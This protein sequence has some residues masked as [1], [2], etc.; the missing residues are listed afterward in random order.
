MKIIGIYKITNPKGKIYIGQSVDVYKRW[1]KGHKYGSNSKTGTGKKLKNSLKKYNWEN[2]L[3]EVIEECNIE[4][5]NEREIYWTNYFD[6]YKTGL[7][8][9]VGG[10]TGYHDDK[11][12][13]NQSNNNKGTKRP[14]LMGK[15]RPEHSNFLKQNGCGLSYERTQKHKD[16]LSLMM[17]E[18]WNMK[19]D[20]ISKKIANNK[21]GKGLKPIICDTLI[22][23]EFKSLTE[24]S[25][26]LRLNKGNICEVLKGNT[27]HTGGL[28]FKYKK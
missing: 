10:F 13:E 22:G 16:N 14:S 2:H 25:N 21:M 4:Q 27:I 1:F 12:K 3:F 24:A 17:K 19:R 23:M 7:N 5:L 18:V 28:T 9:Q 6:S 15:K 26:I 20:E 8:S 11:W